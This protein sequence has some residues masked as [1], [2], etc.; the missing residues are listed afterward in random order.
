MKNTIGKGAFVLIVSGIVCKVFGALFRLPLTN[1][2]SLQGIGVFQMVMSLYS[3]SLGLVSSGVTNALSKLVSGARARGE[4]NKIGGYFRHGLIFSGII[5]L[6][7]GMIFLFLSH[8]IALLQGAR[9]ADISYMLLS[10]LLPLGALIGCFRGVLQGYENMT[11]T[12]ISQII[13]QLFKFAF[14]LFFA[15]L[16]SNSLGGGVFG[17]F[18]GITISEIFAFIYLLFAIKR[19]RIAFN[20]HIEKKEFLKAVTPLTLSAVVLPLVF[21]VESLIIV[22]LL[23]SAGM[24][25]QVAT[26]LYGLSSGV[27]G[28]I[29][30]F[31]LVISL[32]VAVVLLPKISFL[33][34]QNDYIA[35]KKV[36][37]KS[38]MIMWFLIMPLIVGI[39]A[40]ARNLYPIIYSSVT[41]EL[42]EIAVQLTLFS[43]FAVVLSAFS[44]L[45]NSI[46][47]AK[48]YY[49]HSLLFYIIG[50]VAK[51]LSLII[52]ARLPSINI[53]AIPISNV[54]LYSSICICSLIKLGRLIKI[55]AF[56]FALPIVSSF[57]M[58]L[59]VKLWLSFMPNIWGVISGVIIGG[60][61]YMILC[62][63]L[64]KNY[65]KEFKLKFKQKM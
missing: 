45:L 49:N 6:L 39:N 20:R 7:L 14:G 38:L 23:S 37:N 42:V 17:A 4:F 18:L 48:G 36:V 22:S 33:S 60:G 16:F 41:G 27:V 34:E 56:S 19:K 65:A 63:P 62:L 52:L 29:L 1:I 10:I 44:Q 59:A 12:A 13:E 50:G 32:S 58:F 5:S 51:I 21:A 24:E 57:V 25:N 53:Y 46:L 47:Q 61:V 30:H 2:I 3:L 54:V 31:P 15:Y 11:P 40:I 55:D 26:T 35:V 8:P 28:A 64:V 43:G 9:E